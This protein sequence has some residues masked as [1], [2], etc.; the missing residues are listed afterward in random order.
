MG[1]FACSV[2]EIEGQDD[3]TAV[4]EQVGKAVWICI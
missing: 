2:D 4:N 3:I 1:A